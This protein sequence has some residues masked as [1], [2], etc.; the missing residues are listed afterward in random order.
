M[1]DKL[2]TW[3]DNDKPL[4]VLYD[5]IYFSGDDWI[6][7]SNSVF[8]D[9]IGAPDIW[10]NAAHL[11]ICEL[12]FGTGLN[13]LNTAK[14]WLETTNVDQ[15]LTYIAT[16]KHPLT[17]EQL[18]KALTFPEIADVRELLINGF[19]GKSSSFFDGRVT[20]ELL[21]GDSLEQLEQAK[22]NADAWYLDGFAPSKNP[23]MWSEQLLKEIA[24]H[25][26]VGARLATFTAAGF[27]R[28][29]LESVGFKVTKRPGYGNKREMIAARFGDTQD[30]NYASM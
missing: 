19:P 20:L 29:G 26:N 28:R 2:V 27:V 9:G 22:F 25:S 3:L 13:F 7:E 16:E 18:R 8:L 14:K 10:Q 30:K 23:E 24:D 15:K 1:S 4:S 12:G 17:P 21:M 6:F 5:D 11:T